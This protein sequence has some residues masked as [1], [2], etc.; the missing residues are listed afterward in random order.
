MTSD[1]ILL[2]NDQ[3]DKERWDNI[4]SISP[5]PNYSL[6]SYFLDAIHPGWKAL[7]YKD[8]ELIFPIMIKSKIGIKYFMTPI[9]IPFIGI[10]S[11][12]KV[13]QQKVDMF[14]EVIK[15][16]SKYL[17]IY[18]DPYIS[19]LIKD[20]STTN[21]N[22][23][24]LD[25]KKSYKEISNVY[26]TNHKRSILKANKSELKLIESQ[27]VNSLVELFKLNKGSQLKEIKDIHLKSLTNALK[28]T[29]KNKDGL[30]IESHCNEKLICSAFFSICGNRITYVKGFSNNE[31]RKIGAMHFII[32]YIIEKYSSSDFVFD[33]G[34]SNDGKVAKF[35][36]GFGAENINYVRF[37]QNKLP[38]IS[39]YFIN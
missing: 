1:F 19:T 17:D 32:N 10:S 14:F 5:F 30:L 13:V 29:L 35:N 31:G 4:I 6:K 39:N 22:C 15:A 28:A 33:F 12:N 2:K 3:I 7:I 23:Q 24:V 8:Y 20:K 34:G 16:Q 36:Y 37:K 26:S 25:L 11:I 38:K 21:R 18:L 27:N 9:F